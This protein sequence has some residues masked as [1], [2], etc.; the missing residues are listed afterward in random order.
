MN[1]KR[2]HGGSQ[3]QRVNANRIDL[4]QQGVVGIVFEFEDGHGEVAHPSPPRRRREEKR[5]R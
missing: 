1:T 4:E 5:G 2:I 3:A